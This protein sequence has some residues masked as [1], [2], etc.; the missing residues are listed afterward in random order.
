MKEQ[1]ITVEKA[2]GIQGA[3]HEVPALAPDHEHMA[4]VPK[5][6][7]DYRFRRELLT[8]VLGWL[9]HGEHYPL[10]LT[11]PMG[12]GKTS[13]IIEVHARLNLPLHIVTGHDRMETPDLIGQHV[14]IDGDMIFLPGPLLNALRFGHTLL[15]DEVD[16]LDPGTVAG[17]NALRE[18]QP[19][20]VPENGGELVHPAPGFRLVVASNTKGS[21]DVDGVYGGAKRLNGAFVDGFI[22]IEVDYP[23][24]DTELE[25]LHATSPKLDRRYHQA[26]LRVAQE[27]RKA[28]MGENDA[29]DA[30][31]V[32]MSTRS[33]LRWG[34]LVK[35]FAGVRRRGENP[36]LYALR[37]AMTWRCDPETRAF[38]ENL[39][40]AELGED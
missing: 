25:L 27:V 33:L 15:V 2:F 4:F 35:V 31:P 10:W 3:H 1:M 32:T 13:I 17:L 22:G 26:M 11:G 18:G 34:H 24:E 21:G 9:Q 20:T 37:R 14:L 38:I 29:G 23:D 8:D 5:A 39:A 19:I 6:N 7:P 16:M 40:H 28:F 12:C 36:F 30:I